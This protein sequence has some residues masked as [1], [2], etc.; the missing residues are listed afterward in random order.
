MSTDPRADPVRQ[1]QRVKAIKEAEE[2]IKLIGSSEVEFNHEHELVAFWK[3]L[4]DYVKA[5]AA[6]LPPPPSRPITNALPFTN[7]EAREFGKTQLPFG[8]H[9]GDLVRDA[10]EMRPNYLV[11]LA[12]TTFID[13]LR[14]YLASPA[15]AEYLRREDVSEDD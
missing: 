11:W 9:K 8:V 10:F 14:R 13:D 3:K 7:E 15:V 5:Q 6:S 12:N 2:V 4:S 1:Q